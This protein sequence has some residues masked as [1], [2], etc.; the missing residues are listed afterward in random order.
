MLEEIFLIKDAALKSISNG[1]QNHWKYYFC[2]LLKCV[3]GGL[4][5]G[6]EIISILILFLLHWK[7]QL[8]SYVYFIYFNILTVEQIK[9]K[10]EIKL[11]RIH[12]NDTHWLFDHNEKKNC[13]A[14]SQVVAFNKII[15]ITFF[16]SGL[17]I[18]STEKIYPNTDEQ[19]AQGWEKKKTLMSNEA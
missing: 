4:F 7:L 8:A 3:W 1:K 17:Y 19:L 18:Y 11:Y 9:C 2:L 16:L 14:F 10:I 12:K 5:Y 15:W 13:T 6:D